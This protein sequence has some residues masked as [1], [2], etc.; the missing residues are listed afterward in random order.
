MNDRNWRV[1]N[2]FTNGVACDEWAPKLQQLLLK[3]SSGPDR[4][5]KNYTLENM[6]LPGHLS[7]DLLVNENDEILSFCG[8]YNGGRYPEGIY[9][10]LNRTWLS[11]DLRISHG[12]FPFLTSTYILPFQLKKCAADLKLIFLS[13]ENRSGRLFLK[14]WQAHQPA[15]E[16]WSVSDKMIQVVPGVEKKSCFQ[17]ICQ[18]SFSPVT[19]NSKT[20]DEK[21]WLRLKD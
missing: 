21:D 10:V 15:S 1:V 6:Y 13:R 4:L 7:F 3:I 20:I 11:N 8:V 19:W 16:N 12:A 2:A 17:F 5:A 18:R 14:K 9:R